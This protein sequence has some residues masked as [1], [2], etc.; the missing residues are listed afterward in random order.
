M[1]L[2]TR[3]L[4]ALIA[5]VSTAFAVPA[6]HPAAYCAQ[7]LPYGV[8]NVP[9]GVHHVAPVCRT[10]YTLVSDETAKIPIWVAYTLTPAH[11]LG[12]V[13]R[14]NAFTADDS[15]PDGDRAKPTDYAGSGYDIGHIAPDGDMSWD[16]NVE[17]ESFI[18]SNMT[19][20]LPGLNRGIWKLLETSVRAH[21]YESGH[22]LLVYAGPV[23][24][25]AKDAKIGKDQIDVPTAFYKIVV[26]T[27]TGGYTAFLF[28]QEGNQG[29]DLEK[30]H[31][32]LAAVERAT[33]IT[34]PMPRGA[35]DAPIWSVDFK[36]LATA[37]KAQCGK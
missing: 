30:V 31:S 21:A 23:Y 10:A 5:L 26:D 18:L 13:V 25:V 6:Q 12:C 1:K 11:A 15:L 35:K 33:G 3:L 37:K 17:R 27:Q 22:T 2:L 36:A 4:L 28:P 19:P 9:A 14:S 20:Q 34:L 32:T 29:N 16:T 7:F 24:N 8:P